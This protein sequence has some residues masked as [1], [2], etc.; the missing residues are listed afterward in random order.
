MSKKSQIWLSAIIAIIGCVVAC[1]S[2]IPNEYLKLVIAMGAIGYGL[3]GFMKALGSS[4]ST[5]ETNTTEDK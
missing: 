5:E 2:I 3:F 4:G 1:S